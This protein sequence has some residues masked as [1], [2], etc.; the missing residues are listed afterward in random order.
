MVET[1]SKQQ[2]LQDTMWALLADGSEIFS[3]AEGQGET[4]QKYVGNY[5]V[6]REGSERKQLGIDPRNHSLKR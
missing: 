6:V 1:I 3:D 4:D 2:S 5:P